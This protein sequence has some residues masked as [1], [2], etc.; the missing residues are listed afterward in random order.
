M[1][2]Y[3]P[4]LPGPDSEPTRAPD[5]QQATGQPSGGQG[6]LLDAIGGMGGSIPNA[7]ILSLLQGP[8]FGQRMGQAM[9]GGVA[10]MRNQP[11]PATAIIEQQQ[12]QQLGIA[13]M[14]QK[15][16]D[17][18]RLAT[19]WSITNDR[20]NREENRREKH[21]LFTEQNI[22]Q[23]RAT[24]KQALQLKA[25]DNFLEAATTPETRAGLAQAKAKV[26]EGMMGTPVPQ[27][28]IEGW[29]LP[30]PVSE[31]RNKQIATAFNSA[32][33][34]PEK[35]QVA[36]QQ[37]RLD[38]QAVKFYATMVKSDAFLAAN[39]IES[40]DVLHGKEVDRQVKEQDLIDKQ[41]KRAAPELAG[42]PKF[43]MAMR[44]MSQTM[45]PGQQYT[46]LSEPDRAKVFNAVH[47]QAKTEEEQKLRL[48]NNLQT[49]R[50][51]AGI[52]ARLAGQLNKPTNP[53]LVDKLVA[54][55]AQGDSYLKNIA[56]LRADLKG[57]PEDALPASNDKA[58]QLWAQ[59]KRNTLYTND[60]SVFNLMQHWNPITVGL[61]RGYFD[62]K[63]VRSI[64][65]YQK[66][67]SAVDG[68]PPRKVM[69]G[70][71]STLEGLI[72]DKM[73]RDLAVAQVPGSNTPPEV[74]E[75]AKYLTA[76]WLTAP[77]SPLSTPPLIQR[78]QFMDMKTGKPVWATLSPGD[79]I[80]PGYVEIK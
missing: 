76:P 35:Q 45:F 17:Q 75:K 58:S 55:Y 51:L 14:L 64:Q 8:S 40:S 80:P 27:N 68:L 26:M 62:E 57:I 56:Q 65:A 25:Y 42:D 79:P 21:T 41:A 9:A 24:E 73:G 36:A 32:G 53:V 43:A 38:P 52:D 20:L 16:N 10:F 78:K 1:A 61:D 11:N 34:D 74:I 31:Q 60:Q 13:Q 77:S 23:K 19:Q 6:S 72:K 18:Q 59:I 15:M 63:S 3:S 70:Y 2:E 4:D 50:L 39:G 30:S 71:L 7:A 54:P 69:E 66:Q 47:Q 12:Q 48:Q 28:V 29:T 49:E 5:L 67:L 44:S 46:D 33:D 37:F 22:A